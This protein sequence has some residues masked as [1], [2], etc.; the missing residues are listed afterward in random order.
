MGKWYENLENKIQKFGVKNLFVE[1]TREKYRF[2]NLVSFNPTENI[3][4]RNI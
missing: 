3:I 4:N 2:Q 1:L